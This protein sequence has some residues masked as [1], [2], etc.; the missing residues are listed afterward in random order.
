MFPV[1]GRIK[2]ASKPAAANPTRMPE[3]LAILVHTAI[4]RIMARNTIPNVSLTCTLPLYH[5]IKLAR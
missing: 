1:T 3:C 4:T 2:V 5:K